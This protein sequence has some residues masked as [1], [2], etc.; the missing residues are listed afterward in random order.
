MGKVLADAGAL[1]QHLAGGGAG[2]GAAAAVDEILVDALHQLDGGIVQGT[3][4]RKRGSGIFGGQRIG[5]RILRG[6]HEDMR[7][8]VGTAAAVDKALSHLLP[9]Q[10]AA[11]GA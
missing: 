8:I 2:A 9:W 7:R 6:K 4:C 3:A 1:L 5:R 11:G 10:L